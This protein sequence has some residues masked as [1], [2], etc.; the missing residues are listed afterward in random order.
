MY[1]RPVQKL[2]LVLV[3]RPGTLL[4]PSHDCYLCNIGRVAGTKYGALQVRRWYKYWIKRSIIY[5]L[6]PSNEI[7]VL[8]KPLATSQGYYFQYRRRTCVLRNTKKITSFL[9]NEVLLHHPGHS[10]INCTIKWIEYDWHH[11]ILI[12]PYLRLVWSCISYI[13]IYTTGMFNEVQT[14]YRTL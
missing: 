12:K 14:I 11:T 3:V 9:S 10:Y 5:I 1:I 7:Q 2:L 13:Y 6:L 8:S 4:P